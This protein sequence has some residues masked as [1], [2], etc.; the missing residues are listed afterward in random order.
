MKTAMAFFLTCLLLVSLNACSVSNEKS[1][2]TT[3]QAIENTLQQIADK[4][5]SS[6]IV[7]EQ[8]ELGQTTV[9]KT[10]NNSITITTATEGFDNTELQFTLTGNILSADVDLS[11]AVQAMLLVDSIGQI[12]GY[13]DG[14][15]Y[16]TQNSEAFLNYTLE[17]EGVKSTD[18]NA[19]TFTLQIDITKKFPLV[20]FGSAYIEVSDL[21]EKKDYIFGGGSGQD[22]KGNITF[23]YK[24]GYI[25]GYD[26]EVTS[27]VIGEK[28]E[29]T[30]NTYK[31]LMSILEVMFN[32]KEVLTYF[33]SNYPD[34]S[35][36]DK[37]FSGFKIEIDPVQNEWEN[38]VLGGQYL[39]AVRITIDK[40]TIKKELLFAPN[41]QG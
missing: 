33:Q 40:E 39:S 8:K 12:H 7:L 9:A 21:E 24:N 32:G 26:H 22:S 2:K 41:S 38:S 1:N 25:D 5:N 20:D 34:F 13:S 4:I 37:A 18:I 30:E 3:N 31:S 29:L 35:H 36:G 17:K 19:D 11:H 15:T 6:K 16:S 14:E 28:E 10:D 23:F 27:L